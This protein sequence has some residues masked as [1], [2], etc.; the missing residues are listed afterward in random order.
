[1]QLR[2]VKKL[3]DA[4]K[5]TEHSAIYKDVVTPKERWLKV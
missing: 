2:I 3:K 1:M 5:Y 4:I